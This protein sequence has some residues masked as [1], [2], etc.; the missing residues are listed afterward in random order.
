MCISYGNAFILFLLLPLF[1]GVLGKNDFG[2][3]TFYLSVVNWL[4]FANT[5]G[6]QTKIRQL[7]L[8]SKNNKI[9]DA[10]ILFIILSFLVTL[11][12]LIYFYIFESYSSKVIITLILL[13]FFTSVFSLTNAFLIADNKV[14]YSA[15]NQFIFSIIP[16]ILFLLI[17]QFY[18]LTY[19]FRFVFSILIAMVIFYLHKKYFINVLKLKR[20]ATLL[21]LKDSFL[22]NIKIAG[23]SLFDK[24]VSQGDKLFVGVM[25]GFEI[26]AIYA[27]GSQISNILQVSLKAFLVFLEQNIFKKDKGITKEFIVTFILGALLSI[28]IFF[29]MKYCF[30]FFFSEDYLYVLTILPY[31]LLIV[32]LRAVSSTQFSCDLVSNSHVRNLIVQYSLLF[33][34]S[35]F[36]YN[37][38][39]L[40]ILLFVQLLMLM[41]V[42]TNMF[43]FAL[44]VVKK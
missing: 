1:V 25:F 38:E 4:V 5:L 12:S 32:Y 15:I 30:L 44:R 33:L 19:L 16:L 28:L 21:N 31:Q 3:Y 36:M 11:F 27:I 39:Q 34:F 20:L 40:D 24:I 29:V 13:S 41:T 18:E 43:N 9:K 8:Q 10:L 14:N 26:L 2:E 37:F 17:S 6:T 23:N 42:L 35:I 7:F 22:D